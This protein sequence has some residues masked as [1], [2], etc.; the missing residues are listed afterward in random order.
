MG[1][2]SD[3]G[4]ARPRGQ[5]TR[6][7]P[8]IRTRL[9]VPAALAVVVLATVTGVVL[10]G[11][12]LPGREA[13]EALPVAGVGSAADCDRVVEVSLVV[14]S[15]L[16]AATAVLDA[17]PLGPTDDGL[18]ARPRVVEL[19]PAQALAGLA[20]GRDGERRPD[21]WLPD[22][23]VWAHR[24][25][26]AGVAV[27]SRGS[28]GTTPVVIA[29][30][31]EVVSALGWRE[32]APTWTE[33]LGGTDRALAVP[34]LAGS[35]GALM[36]I[37]AAQEAAGDDASLLT[38]RT[39]LARQRAGSLTPSEGLVQAASDGAAAPLVVTSEQ[40]VLR[41][42]DG[43]Q[44]SPLAAVAPAGG[45]PVLDYPVLAVPPVGERDEDDAA[46]VELVLAALT[47]GTGRAMAVEAGL[48]GPGLEPLPGVARLV[49]PSLPLLLEPDQEALDRLT[50]DLTRLAP[51]SELLV[52]VDVSLSMS[53]EVG[54]GFT[55][56]DVAAE[57][58]DRALVDLPDSSRVGLWQFASQ[59]DGEQDHVEVLPVRELGGSVDGRR[60]RDLL[61][62]EV[63]ALPESLVSGGTS[64]YDTV[65]AAVASAQEQWDDQAVSTVVVITDGRN[66]DS[67]GLDL[68]GLIDRLTE[69]GD[70]ERPVGLVLVGFGPDADLAALEQ[71]AA[72][73]AGGPAQA[74][75]ARNPN[76]LQTLLVQL[77]AARTA[78]ATET[79][80]P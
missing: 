17:A 51:P 74:V 59:L 7:A 79:P 36:A 52:V 64:L 37:G 45:T 57:A 19:A 72:T 30:S 41:R 22:S 18:C 26:L 70:P 77:L 62:D 76:A 16:S 24:A 73:G 69:V 14:G 55:R 56:A 54:D 58:L 38:V 21:V 40:D 8:R 27:E 71:V 15:E 5:R 31:D 20:A 53:G 23:T 34:D 48:R 33:V 42:T 9:V 35:A 12:G 1:R 3:V 49:E 11:V 80:A 68:D 67:T 39:A 25:E 50:A 63:A 4:E 78:G 43:A 44:R 28:L 60:Q 66:E 61:A 46:A 10:A 29:T 65:A 47:S 6:Q 13:V 32:T 75:D 2:H